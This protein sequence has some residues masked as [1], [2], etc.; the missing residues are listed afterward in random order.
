MAATVRADFFGASGTE[1]AG[2][3]AE[4]GIVFNREDT[5]TGTTAVPIPT[6]TGTNY[7]WRKNLGLN[8]TA[9]AATT[10]SNRR[11]YL[12][13]APTTG[14]YLFYKAASSYTQAS[15]GDAPADNTSSNG[16]TPA[17]YTALTATTLGGAHVW[18]ATGVSAGSTGRNGDFLVLL[19]GVGN[20]Y[21]GG[22]GSAISL[23]THTLAYDEA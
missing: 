2:S 14:L 17:T 12:S 8:V 19:L 11:V 18:H 10:I 5:K 3:T 4:S 23:P 13:G 6:A 1:P 15:S 16:A 22:A 21:S 9:T 7:S 20:N